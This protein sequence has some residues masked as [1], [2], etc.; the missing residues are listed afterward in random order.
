MRCATPTIEPTGEL[1]RVLGLMHGAHASFTSL[2]ADVSGFY[3]PGVRHAALERPCAAGQAGFGAVGMP[4]E[5]VNEATWRLWVE[6]PGRTRAE[7]SFLIDWNADRLI[8]LE[9]GFVL[10][11]RVWAG[12]RVVRDLSMHSVAFG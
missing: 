4:T 12:D 7:Q 5:P 8:D 9:A 10:R 11:L 1:G 3:D 6:Q 2:A